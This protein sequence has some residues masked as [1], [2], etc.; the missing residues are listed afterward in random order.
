MILIILKGEIDNYN[1]V[2]KKILDQYTFR[3]NNIEKFEPVLQWAQNKDYV[4]LEVFLTNK[5]DTITCNKV[6]NDYVDL[7]SHGMEISG[8]CM[9]EDNYKKF[10]LKLSFFDEILKL[11]SNYHLNDEGKYVLFLKKKTPFEWVNFAR[12]EK[13]NF[14]IW[15]EMQNKF[16]EEKE[17]EE[18]EEEV[19][20][21]P[22]KKKS[23]RPEYVFR[24]KE[25]YKDSSYWD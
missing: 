8:Y 20:E 23:R 14:R 24:G 13:S 25:L 12:N 19:V 1:N 5:F 15:E 21:K 18:K 16:D 17:E 6:E 2:L 7:M 4:M 11:N 9:M 3:Q 10:E 22:V